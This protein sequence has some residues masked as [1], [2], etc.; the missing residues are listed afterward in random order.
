MVALF[1]FETC[2]SLHYLEDEHPI[3]ASRFTRTARNVKLPTY[4]SPNEV[5]LHRGQ[6]QHIRCPSYIKG[7][8]VSLVFWFK[9][10][11]LLARYT[12]PKVGS[13]YASSDRYR[14]S[15]SHDLIISH[16][17]MRDQGDYV[18]S[19]VPTAT[20]LQRRQSISVTVMTDVPS[21]KEA[22][23]LTEGEVYVHRN[24]TH[25]IQCPSYREGESVS[26]VFW[27]KGGQLIARFANPAVGTNFISS[28]RYWMSSSHGLVI[29][30]VQSAD[31]GDYVCGV[32]P[33][34]TGLQRKGSVRVTVLVGSTMESATSGN[35][36]YS[37]EITHQEITHT[38]QGN[39]PL[40]YD[41]I[42]LSAEKL[43]DVSAVQSA[44]PAVVCTLAVIVL[45]GICIVVLVK[46]RQSNMNE[47][48]DSEQKHQD[49]SKGS[50][51]DSKADRST[52]PKERATRV[53]HRTD[54]EYAAVVDMPQDRPQGSTENYSADRSETCT[55]V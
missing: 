7:E 12:H 23:D 40:A 22:M 31:E 2:A 44:V 52:T 28:R 1:V 24:Q 39:T 54:T 16:V 29:Y 18:C 50:T 26:L 33:S 9:G 32:V 46:M 43:P 35:V 6:T 3:G 19:V 34:A 21:F 42:A 55:A 14:M 20:A 13:S 5:I 4:L 48:E 27:F 49:A 47:A 17:D 41:S 25:H 36:D 30:Q 38:V 51:H 37:D 45:I 53:A 8:R 10:E 11:Q 15:H